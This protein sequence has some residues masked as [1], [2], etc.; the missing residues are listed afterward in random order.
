MSHF[1]GE[2]PA[3][4]M[5]ERVG[6]AKRRRD[7]WLLAWH[8]HERLTVAMELGTALHHSAQQDSGGGAERGVGSR[9]VERL[10]GTDAASTEGAARHPCGAWAAEE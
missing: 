10:A 4:A 8:R 1:L 9:A 7:R 3:V 5:S 6:A 2:N